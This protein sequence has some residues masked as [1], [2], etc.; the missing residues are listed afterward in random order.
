MMS[1]IIIDVPVLAYKT[2]VLNCI[3]D[4]ERDISWERELQ[5]SLKGIGCDYDPDYQHVK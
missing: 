1:G 4:G 5:Q 3:I 2:W